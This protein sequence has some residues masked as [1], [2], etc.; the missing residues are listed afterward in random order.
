[1]NFWGISNCHFCNNAL[2]TKNIFLC[3]SA[4][5]ILLMLDTTGLDFLLLTN[6]CCMSL[7]KELY[8]SLSSSCF[9]QCLGV[10]QKKHLRS[11]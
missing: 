2:K 9:F 8:L 10:K 5:I 7:T 3:V 6:P 4:L 1:M 11:D